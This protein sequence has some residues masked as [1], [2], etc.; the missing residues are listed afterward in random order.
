MDLEQ[1]TVNVAFKRADQPAFDGLN[2]GNWWQYMTYS[3][4][5]KCF[6]IS[7]ADANGIFKAWKDTEGKWQVEKFAGFRS[8]SPAFGDRLND[9]VLNA[10]CGMAVNSDGE[11][12]VCLKGSHCIVKIK[13]RLVSLVAGKPGSYGKVNGYP[14]ESYFDQPSAI[15]IDSD[16]NF[17]IGEVVTRVVRKMTIE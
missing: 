6:Y 14:L 16:E 12:Y 9:A 3:K 5:D 11:L 7:C 13:G 1:K 17:Y 8:G 15:A 2:L 4:Y 10:P